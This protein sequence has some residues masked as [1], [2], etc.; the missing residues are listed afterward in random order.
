MKIKPY[1]DRLANSKEFKNFE[2]ENADAFMMAGFFIIDIE[3]GK[4][5]HQ[6]DYYIPSKKKIAAFTIDK[7]VTMQ[8]LSSINSKIP[9]KL[10]IKT[11]ID[12]DAL[13]GILEDEMKNRNITEEIKK[14]IAVVQNIDGKK[15]WNVNCILSGMEILKAHVE[16]ESESVLKMEKSSILDY[17]KK[18]PASALKGMQG[19]QGMSGMQPGQSQMQVP[20]EGSQIQIQDPESEEGTDPGIAK[21]KIEQ[22]KKLE[23]AI[24]REK[25]RIEGQAIEQEKKSAVK[26]AKAKPAKAAKAKKK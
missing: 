7:G 23:E 17:I 13:K 12:M 25:K 2:K 16:D 26:E 21:K 4:N 15:V 3:S 5:L 11:K 9:E 19:M 8:I 14:M 20:Q 18:M 10:D 1:V 22:L 24:E 6:I